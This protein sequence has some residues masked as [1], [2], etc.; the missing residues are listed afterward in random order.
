[1]ETIGER[2]RKAR[3]S[4]G[5]T[6]E[7]LQKITKVQ[8]RYLSAVEDNQF[9]LLPGTYYARNFI[10]QYAQAVGLD[11]DELVEVYDGGGV[12]KSTAV[13]ENQRSR[14]ELNRKKHRTSN[15]SKDKWPML[16]LSLASLLIIATVFWLTLREAK[17]KQV[18]Q[19]NNSDVLVEGSFEESSD[20]KETSES[21]EKEKETS[22]SK[23]K[24]EKQSTVEVG[25]EAGRE[26]AIKVASHKDPAE[27][28]VKSTGGRCWIGI[29]G[30]GQS[31]YNGTVEANQTVET[32]LTEG[33]E[34][35][36]ITLGA[37]NAVEVFVNG[38]KVDFNKSG[39]NLDMRNLN[40]SLTYD[41][42]TEE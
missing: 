22:E 8:A 17:P 26:L 39:S 6:I 42:K 4:K 25:E 11:G 2:L 41:K 16:L 1:M 27:I 13:I 14:T 35:A 18:I 7:D 40:L 5:I 19:T 3:L 15:I 37:A 12:S 36:V 38:E 32:T 30:N 20:K 21:K 29:N 28:M 24:E 10:R 9:E 34:N 33:M 23:E 31:L